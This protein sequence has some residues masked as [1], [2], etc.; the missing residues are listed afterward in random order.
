MITPILL[1]YISQTD[2]IEKGGVP[3]EL[4]ADIKVHACRCIQIN[5]K[6]WAVVVAL[7]CE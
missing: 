1:P 5:I 4:F 2:D 7:G 3:K 6:E